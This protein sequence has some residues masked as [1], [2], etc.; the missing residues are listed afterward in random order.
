M[1][2]DYSYPLYARFLHAG[3]AVFGVTAYATSEFAEEGTGGYL[4]HAYLGLSLAGFVLVRVVAGLSQRPALGFAGWSPLSRGQWKLAVDDLRRLVR[5]DVPERGMHEG[6]AGLTQAAG[7]ALFAWMGATGT[8]MFVLD[9][10][11]KSDVFEALEE[12]HEV[13]ESL[14][15]IYL[16]LHVGSVVVHGFAGHPIWRRMWTFRDGT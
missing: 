7:I 2:T 16:I 6:L 10:G 5:F 9:T 15:P 11:S 3:M 8:G 14:I 1:A 4:L 12:L 13:G